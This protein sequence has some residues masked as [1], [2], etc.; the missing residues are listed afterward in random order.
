MTND[1]LK[2]FVEKRGYSVFY[3]LMPSWCHGNDKMFYVRKLFVLK[4]IKS[5]LSNI[6]CTIISD[7]VKNGS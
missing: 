1:E 6:I 3:I 7:V 2:Q 5:E 4:D